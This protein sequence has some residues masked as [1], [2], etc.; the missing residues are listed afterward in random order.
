MHAA[1]STQH[2]TTQHSTGN[3]N[4]HLLLAKKKRI[5]VEANFGRD[6]TDTHGATHVFSLLSV[7]GPGGRGFNLYL[8]RRKIIVPAAWWSAWCVNLE[9]LHGIKVAFFV[10]IRTGTYKNSVCAADASVVFCKSAPRRDRWPHPFYYHHSLLMTWHVYDVKLCAEEF[11]TYYTYSV[12]SVRWDDSVCY[13][14]EVE[15][16]YQI[17]TFH[18][19]V[20]QYYCNKK[21]SPT[22]NVHLT[23]SIYKQ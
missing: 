22:S 6:T 1:S 14:V 23:Y 4:S 7:C 20:S 11:T 2:T 19:P 10:N 5:L 13:Q 18:P 21:V 8:C 12:Y 17:I 9:I 3:N 15:M 16:V